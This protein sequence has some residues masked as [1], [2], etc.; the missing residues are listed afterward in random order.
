MQ[1]MVGSVYCSCEVC[2]YV[3]IIVV[4]ICQNIVLYLGVFFCGFIVL[5][6]VVQVCVVFFGCDYILLDDVCCMVLFVFSYRLIFVL[7]VCMCGM[8]VEGILC[9]LFDIL[10]V[11]GKQV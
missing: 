3:V 11:F 10:V 5:I 6:W 1:D 2:V 7:E 9:Q 4:V 8:M